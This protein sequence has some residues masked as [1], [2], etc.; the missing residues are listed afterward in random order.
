M[1]TNLEILLKDKVKQLGLFLISI[2][3][4]ETKKKDINDTLIDIPFYKI[5]MFI[6]F[7]NVNKI[8]D[9]INDF[10]K[11]FKLEITEENRIKI[12]DYIL[13]FIT[14]ARTYVIYFTTLHYY[15]LY[16][17]LYTIQCTLCTALYYILYHAA[18]HYTVYIV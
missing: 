14:T 18:I 4:N 11:L 3:D 7:L 9:Q 8:D 6:S 15:T 13:Y 12:F 16:Y 2:C 1:E 17:T 5:M 10:I